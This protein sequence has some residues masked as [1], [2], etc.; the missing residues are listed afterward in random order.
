MVVIG[1]ILLTL[2]ELALPLLLLVPLIAL[3]HY[4]DEISNVSMCVLSGIK[5]RFYCF[6]SFD[7]DKPS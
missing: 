7:E 4:P 5:T 3:C 6:G 2:L 1:K